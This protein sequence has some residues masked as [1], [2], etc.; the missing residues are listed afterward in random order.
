MKPILFAAAALLLA[1]GLALAQ[2]LSGAWTISSSVGT[3]PITVNCTL[4]QKGEALS[5]ACAPAAGTPTAFTGVVTGTHASW[6][7]DVTFRGQPAHVGFEADISSDTAMTG[8]LKLAGK[9]SPFT[10]VRK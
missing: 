9:P 4:V 10:A 5:G 8:V 1:P 7:Y 3:T 6:G 2:D